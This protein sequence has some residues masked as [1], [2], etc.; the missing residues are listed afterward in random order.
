[1]F[2]LTENELASALSYANN[3]VKLLE[4]VYAGHIGNRPGTG[5]KSGIRLKFL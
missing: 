5:I 4:K 2:R 3:P 1:V